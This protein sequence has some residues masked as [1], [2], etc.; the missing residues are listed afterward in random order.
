MLVVRGVDDVLVEQQ[1]G[2]V[3]QGP[4]AVLVWQLDT[5]RPAWTKE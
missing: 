1:P 4:G 2:R 3:V 5:A